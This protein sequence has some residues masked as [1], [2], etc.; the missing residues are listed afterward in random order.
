MTEIGVH[1]ECDRETWYGG[2]VLETVSL[3]L[4]RAPSVVE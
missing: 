3:F 2:N 1:L 4:I